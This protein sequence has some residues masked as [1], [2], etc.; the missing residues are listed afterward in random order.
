MRRIARPEKMMV[1]KITR[2]PAFMSVGLDPPGVRERAPHPVRTT[3][4]GETTEPQV[5]GV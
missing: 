5:R 1:V 2:R 4:P 3:S